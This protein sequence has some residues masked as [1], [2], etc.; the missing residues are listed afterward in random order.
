[1]SD[2]TAF[3]PDYVSARAR[4]R[5]A[6]LAIGARTEAIE[7]GQMGPDGD[8]LTIDVAILGAG[9]PKRAVVVSSG[10][11]GIEGFFGSA[12]Q[13]ALLEDVLGG[14][15]P[16]DDCALVFLHAL[17]PYGFAWLRRVNEDNAD[18]NRNFLGEGEA[19]TGSPEKYAALDNL[20]NPPEPPSALSR[21]TFLPKAVWNILRLGMP[22]LKNAV[23][24]GQYDYPMGLFFGGSGPSKTQEI[25]DQNLPR[26]VGSCRRVVHIDFHTGLG[27]WGTYK[28]F[29][30]HEKGSEG[31]AKLA[32]AFGADCVEA[33]DNSGTSYTIRGGM[34]TWCKS[35]LPAVN[36]DVLAAEFGTRHVLQVISALH[37]ENR[38]RNWGGQDHPATEPAKRKLRDTFAPP[39]RPWRDAVVPKGVQIVMTAMDAAFAE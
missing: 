25:L 5:S 35:R 12:V 13:A 32:K 20:L 16:P 1:M 22:A 28:L 38:A 23:A 31:E 37:D 26:W 24:G 7:I 39:E 3:S 11:H 34:G 21:M 18:L 2:A 36:Y 29:V 15:T 14:Y 8:V 9:S 4:F 6:A 19:Y 17:N 33:W 10:L 27:P 30:D